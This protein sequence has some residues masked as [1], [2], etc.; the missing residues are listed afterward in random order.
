M[1]QF[2]ISIWYTGRWMD[3]PW[4][5]FLEIAMPGLEFDIETNVDPNL[6]IR[7]FNKSILKGNFCYCIINE[8][9]HSML[10]KI[11]SKQWIHENEYLRNNELILCIGYVNINK[12]QKNTFDDDAF[13]RRYIV[14]PIM[15]T[16]GHVCFAIMS[17][18]Y[19]LLF[20]G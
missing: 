19:V 20:F 13:R 12:I 1:M 4:L 3:Y 9:F 2:R 14:C 16:L 6:F 15:S 10:C 8:I 17:K 7:Y 18:Y 5:W 11:C